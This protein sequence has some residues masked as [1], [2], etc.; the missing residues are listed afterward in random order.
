MGY[1]MRLNDS[2]SSS[3]VLSAACSAR[4]GRAGR[5]RRCAALLKPVGDVAWRCT[6]MPKVYETR[7]CAG[8]GMG[9]RVAADPVSVAHG[10]YGI[11][12]G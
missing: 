1:L 6:I 2:A 10:P 7:G 8:G 12:V 9:W 11:C 3:P 5:M 4:I